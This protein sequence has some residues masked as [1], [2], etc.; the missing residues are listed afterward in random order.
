MY[1]AYHGQR[2]QAKG[3]AAAGGV[4][5]GEDGGEGVVQVPGDGA[6]TAEHGAQPGDQVQQRPEADG[7]QGGHP[8]VRPQHQGRVLQ[9]AG[10]EQ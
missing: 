3:V 9:V 2:N 8:V 1:L 10:P 6:V 7:D 5:G 4:E